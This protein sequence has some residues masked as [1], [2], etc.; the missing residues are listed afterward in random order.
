MGFFDKV[1]KDGIIPMATGL[2]IPSKI[3]D[4]IIKDP[5][6]EGKKSG[7]SIAAEEYEPILEELKNEIKRT[8]LFFETEMSK[9]DKKVDIFIKKLQAL[10][11]EKKKYVKLLSDK[12]RELQETYNYE[13]KYATATGS[14]FIGIGLYE[15]FYKR[16]FD[17]AEAE[18]YQEAKA[19]YVKKI[20]ALKGQLTKLIKQ[21]QSEL[22]EHDA[23][24]TETQ[25][26]I[27][28][29]ISEIS[30]LKLDIAEIDLLL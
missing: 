30:R 14:L 15:F 26:S 28:E 24:F 7:Y 6:I 12:K 19:T 9:K 10:E 5:K 11:K 27:S 8:K 16:N 20:S 2:Y 18:G 13:T 17:K 4:S 25:K 1:F 29:I 21:Y 3:K 22:N 23:I